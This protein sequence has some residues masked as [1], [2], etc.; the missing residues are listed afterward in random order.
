M[1]STLTIHEF[2]EF[3]RPP[4]PHAATTHV[5]TRQQMPAE[6]SPRILLS[7][8]SHSR[9]PIFATIVNSHSSSISCYSSLSAAFSHCL[10][11]T[12][13]D[14]KTLYFHHIFSFT[15]GFLMPLAFR[16]HSFPSPYSVD[17]PV[18]LPECLRLLAKI[19]PFS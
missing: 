7:Y 4:P 13:L 12:C 3:Q 14:P 15:S 2:A 11:R 8:C 1:H 6:Y 5:P 9:K 17:L 10:S 16:N 18:L 19:N